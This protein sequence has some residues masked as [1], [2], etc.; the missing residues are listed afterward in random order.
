M[1][2]NN[3]PITISSAM[4]TKYLQLCQ[5]EFSIKQTA[6]TLKRL[7]LAEHDRAH[8]QTK[9]DYPNSVYNEGY[10]S[11]RAQAFEVSA[12]TI[13]DALVATEPDGAAK[14]DQPNDDDRREPL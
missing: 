6:E 14:G 1:S 7:A 8:Q 9:R 10:H 11:G 5:L 4:A 3:E 2:T 12:N 13:R